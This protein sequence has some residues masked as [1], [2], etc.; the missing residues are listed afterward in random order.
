MSTRSVEVRGVAKRFGDHAA[1][2]EIDLSIE[3]GEFLSLLGPSGC[4]KTTL[5]RIVAGFEQP[6]VGRILIHG[7]DMTT[8]PPHRR[9]T[10][11]VFQR[12]ALFPHMNVAENIGYS[13]KLR[14]WPRS[15]IS[16]RVEE[17]LALVRLEGLGR[18]GATELSGGQIQRVAL[19]RAL[20]PE[21]EVL[22]LDEPLSALDLK[23]RQHMQLELRA[24]HRQLG[25]TFVYVTHDQVEAMVMSDRIAVMNEGRIIQEGSPREI[26][27]RPASVFAS[28]FIGDTNLIAGT[29]TGAPAGSVKLSLASGATLSGESTEDLPLGTRA[30]LSVRPEAIRVTPHREAREG[31]PSGPIPSLR[32]EIAEIIYLGNRV[33]L[34]VSAEEDLIV[35][36]DLREEEAE[37]LERGMTVW[38]TWP[39]SAASVWADR[40]DQSH[41]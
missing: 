18:R 30:T 24:I 37:H 17:M 21:P 13:L 9:P 26:Y 33:R 12:G 25:A 35:I 5:L 4:G 15:R 19:A 27:T 1:L 31:E 16:A 38:L 14:K 28:D 3:Q 10:N 39:A 6:S 36:A 29:V 32:A 11:M 41:R 7:T 40:S 8:V 23:L 2:H 20:A 22:L 34:E